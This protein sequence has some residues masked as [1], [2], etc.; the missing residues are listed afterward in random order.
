MALAGLERE[1]LL[2]H[3]LGV[4]LG[5]RV[6]SS[7]KGGVERTVGLIKASHRLVLPL[8]PHAIAR[9]DRCEQPSNQAPIGEENPKSKGQEKEGGGERR[10]SLSKPDFIFYCNPPRSLLETR[11]KRIKRGRRKE[12]GVDRQRKK[13]G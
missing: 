12:K 2:G 1:L 10:E 13:S 5:E 9:I 4:E 11:T 8:P 7:P 3:G 6:G